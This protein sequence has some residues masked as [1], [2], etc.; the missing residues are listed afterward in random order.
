MAS[1]ENQGLQIALILFV[2]VTIGLA[3]TTFVFYKKAQEQSGEVEE[4]DFQYP[5]PIPFS[6][7]TAILMM[8]DSVE[9]ASRTL[10]TYTPGTISDLVEGIVGRQAEESQ[11]S[12]ANLTFADISAA[13]EIF[14]NRLSN[15]YHSRIEYPE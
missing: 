13:K 8:A 2:M 12:E 1:R 11:F 10:K 6:K 14:K 5:G 3:V 4:K 7:E 9:A 15:I